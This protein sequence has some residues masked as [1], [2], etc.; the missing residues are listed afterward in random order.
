MA[1]RTNKSFLGSGMKFPPQANRATGRFAVSANEQSVKE[2]VYLILMT[3][4]GERE[5]APGF[6][7]RLSRYAFM[8]VNITNL[9]IM[10]H[11]IAELIMAQEPRVAAA[12]AD[13]DA[14]S[15]DDCLIINITYRVAQT[16]TTDNFVFPFYLR[17]SAG[18]DES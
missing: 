4:A 10:Q 7:S 11:D 2:S 9:N 13:I 15:R 18:A 14:Q 16:N 17:A 6:G 3:A 1:D 12:D 5:L 8:D